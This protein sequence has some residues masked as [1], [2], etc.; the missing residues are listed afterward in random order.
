[1]VRCRKKTGNGEIQVSGYFKLPALIFY[2]QIRQ[3]IIQAVTLTW[4]ST[5]NIILGVQ[6]NIKTL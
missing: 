1:M 4:Y 6:L 5:V 2:G 3:V